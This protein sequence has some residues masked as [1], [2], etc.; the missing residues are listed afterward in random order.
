MLDTRTRHLAPRTG[1]ADQGFAPLGGGLS[2]TP[3]ANTHP[4]VTGLHLT[5]GVHSWGA[6]KRVSETPSQ[7]GEPPVRGLA[8]R[9]PLATGEEP[10]EGLGE[11]LV[12]WRCWFPAEFPAGQARVR[13]VSGDFAGAG[14]L[15]LDARAAAEAGFGE[16]GEAL[17]E[18]AH[19]GLDATADLVDAV[20]GTPG[21]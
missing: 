10:V 12:E 11:A 19:R 17:E 3:S 18:I 14:R 20:L 8:G 6:G 16:V 15:V 5:R 9:G 13:E 4:V 7:G 1:G 21:L 2:T